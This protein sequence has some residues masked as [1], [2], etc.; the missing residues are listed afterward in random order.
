[1]AADVE[2]TWLKI[3]SDLE[4]PLE[5][6]NEWWCKILGQYSED[7]RYYHNSESLAFK[8]KH[9]HEIEPKLKNPLAVGLAIIFQ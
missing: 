7:G 4:I 3:T 6:R 8:F 5:K 2:E 1:M 9:F